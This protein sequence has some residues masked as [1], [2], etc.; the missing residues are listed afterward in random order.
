MESRMSN[1]K[2][3]FANHR[4]FIIGGRGHTEDELRTTFDRFGDIIDVYLVK[5]RTTKEPKGSM[6]M[7]IIRKHARGVRCAVYGCKMSDTAGRELAIT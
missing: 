5:D 7:P 4:I 3:N 1:E 2:K 6:Q